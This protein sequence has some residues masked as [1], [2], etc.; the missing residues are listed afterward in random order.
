MGGDLAVS[1]DLRPPLQDHEGTYLST[2]SEGDM[3]TDL[4]IGAN[5]APLTDSCPG[6]HCC[7]RMNA[8]RLFPS[9][10][11]SMIIIKSSASAANAPST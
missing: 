5:A 3:L 10:P 4:G 6:R 2:L 7:R 9:S 11:P 8:Q 1:P